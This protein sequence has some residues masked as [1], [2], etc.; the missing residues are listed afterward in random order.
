MEHVRPG[1]RSATASTCGGGGNG[2]SRQQSKS[3]TPDRF[4]GR[5]RRAGRGWLWRVSDSSDGFLSFFARRRF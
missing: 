4:H 3:T 1:A 2:R 5:L